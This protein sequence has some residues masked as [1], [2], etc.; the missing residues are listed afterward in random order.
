VKR[1][2][3]WDG[4]V[5]WLNVTEDEVKSSYERDRTP[6]SSTYYM[7]A[8]PD[9]SG[10]AAPPEYSFPS[11]FPHIPL[12][13]SRYEKEVKVPAGDVPRVYNCPL[14]NEIF[15]SEEELGNHVERSAH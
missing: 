9:Y 2:E 6:D 8:H 7:E 11:P 13:L 4:R 10:L 12:K 1:V 14:C 15:Q 5:L 3:G